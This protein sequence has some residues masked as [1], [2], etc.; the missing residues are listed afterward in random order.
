MHKQ[1]GRVPNPKKSN[2]RKEEKTRRQIAL[3]LD[4][5]KIIIYRYFCS[6]IR[7]I[8][9]LKCFWIKLEWIFF[10]EKMTE[11]KNKVEHRQTASIHGNDDS[12]FG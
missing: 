8:S 6:D 1:T 12:N 4:N 11:R 5:P 9:A 10:L 7:L 3:G 2:K